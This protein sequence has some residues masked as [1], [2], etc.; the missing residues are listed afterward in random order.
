MRFN[1]VKKEDILFLENEGFVEIPVVTYYELIRLTGPCMVV[2]FRSG[3]L[4]LQGKEKAVV[5]YASTLSG[6]GLRGNVNFREERGIIIGSDEALKGDTFGGIV[7]AGVRADVLLRENLLLL[8]VMDSKKIPDDQIYPL[9]AAIKKIV[10]Y[11]VISLFAEQYNQKPGD[12][13]S[14]LNSL[15]S[16]VF[17]QLNVLGAVHIVDE[18]PG[19]TVGHHEPHAESNYIEVAA[20]SILAREGALLQLRALSE[21]LGYTVPKGS[22]HVERALSYLKRTKKDPSLYVKMHFKNV[23]SIFC[24]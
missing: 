18:Y 15:H 5:Q 11:S 2:L 4:I 14:L 9:A 21:M 6:K 24:A 3:T 1:N 8:G 22:T 13:T 7:V 19:C 23:K 10:P 17:S 12:V 20:G 16:E